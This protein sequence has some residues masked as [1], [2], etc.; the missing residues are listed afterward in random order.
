M[1]RAAGY[2]G[3]RPLS[4]LASSHAASRPTPSLLLQRR[5]LSSTL[6]ETH[7]QHAMLRSDVKGLGRML[8]E[9]ISAHSGDTIFHK[10]GNCFDG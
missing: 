3:L 1:L 10:V 4:L 5:G 6:S 9:A 2:R 8:G 7:E